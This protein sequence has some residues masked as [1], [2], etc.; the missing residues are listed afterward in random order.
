[1]ET[2]ERLLLTPKDVAHKLSL[3]LAKVYAMLASG[4]LACV[5]IGRSVRIPAA[6]LNAFLSDY[7]A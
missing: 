6:S 2:I 5:R 1:M 7:S 3:S 4:Q